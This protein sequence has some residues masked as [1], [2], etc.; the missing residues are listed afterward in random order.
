MATRRPIAQWVGWLCVIAGLV[1]YWRSSVE[2][3]PAAP[4]TALMLRGEAAVD[5]HVETLVLPAEPMTASLNSASSWI[6]P[7][8]WS[9]T[10]SVVTHDGSQTY[11]I[12]PPTSDGVTA[13][14]LLDRTPPASGVIPSNPAFAALRLALED[15]ARRRVAGGLAD[16]KASDLREQMSGNSAVLRWRARYLR[17]GEPWFEYGARVLSENESQFVFLHAQAS[18]AEQGSAEFQQ[19]LNA[20]LPR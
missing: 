2:E 15:L 11:F 6:A 14:V 7:A 18:S 8:G 10:R 17:K 20:S 19:L 4:V 12:T 13:G 1:I 5:R 9:V 16:Y 3:T